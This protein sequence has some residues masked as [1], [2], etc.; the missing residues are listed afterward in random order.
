[1]Y[2]KRQ[3]AQ[4]EEKR[5]EKSLIISQLVSVVSYQ[6]SIRITECSALYRYS[7]LLRASNNVLVSVASIHRG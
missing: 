4:V 3:T 6:L 2:S 1:M 7:D 5:A